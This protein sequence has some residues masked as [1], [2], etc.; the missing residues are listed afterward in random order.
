M[1]TVQ[2]SIAGQLA[3]D[4][5]PTGHADAIRTQ[6]GSD[7]FIVVDGVWLGQVLEAANGPNAIPGAALRNLIAAQPTV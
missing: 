2:G 6:L 1:A 3:G 5:D 7:G 4:P